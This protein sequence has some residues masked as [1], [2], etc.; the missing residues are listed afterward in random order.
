MRNVEIRTL[1]A[2]EIQ[3]RVLQTA[4]NNSWAQ[5]AL[6]KD[7]RCDQAVLDE[8]FGIFG[9]KRSH[10]LIDTELFCT[11]EIYDEVTKQWV[12]KQDVGKESFTAKEKGEASD[13][14]KRACVN[15]GIGRELYSAP[16]DLFINLCADDLTKDG[17]VRNNWF[18]V[19]E[20]GYNEARKINKLVIVDAYNRQRYIYPNAHTP[21]TIQ[22][23]EQPAP[24]SENSLPAPTGTPQVGIP[25]PT[26]QAPQNDEQAL[27]TKAL[28]EVEAATTIK[29]L[30]EIYNS[31]QGSVSQG[32]FAVISNALTARRKALGQKKKGEK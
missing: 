2:E 6:Y 29:R 25:A 24:T 12:S 30:T 32:G 1:R 27:V 21:K 13:A 9:W 14:F 26:A 17:K 7:A 20:I 18:F 5:L 31:Y 15:I 8:T 19:S 4:K 23:Q 16:K 28:K 22:N 11:V 10:Q 3:C